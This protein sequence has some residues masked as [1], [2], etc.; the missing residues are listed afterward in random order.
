MKTGISFILLFLSLSVVTIKAQSKQPTTALQQTFTGDA[1][2][3]ENLH[4]A[5]I[6]GPF[7]SN[8]YRQYANAWFKKYTLKVSAPAGWHFVGQPYVHCVKDDQGAFAWNNFPAA[9]D[10]FFITQQNANYIVATCWAG[11]RSMIINLACLAEQDSP[12]A[13][14]GK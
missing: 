10:R 3:T 7:D 4:D 9:H 13:V 5:R 12:H 2:T 14:D 1:I 6:Q 8:V 11:S